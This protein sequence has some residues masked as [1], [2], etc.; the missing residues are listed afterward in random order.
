MDDLVTA[1]CDFCGNEIKV[2][3][4]V[5]DCRDN[6]NLPIICSDECWEVSE[7]IRQRESE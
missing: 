4:E 2:E 3:Q 6:D 1:R 5:V 7:R